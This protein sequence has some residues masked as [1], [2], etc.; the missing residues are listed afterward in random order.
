M[1]V[2]AQRTA[3]FLMLVLFL[4]ASTG[5]VLEGDT[6]WHIKTGEWIW[7]NH[8][9]PEVDVF[10]YTAQTK[11]PVRPHSVRHD[12]IMKG[13]WL[14]QPLLYL[15]H[16]TFGV[17]GLVMMRALMVALV[18]LVLHLWMQRL[19]VRFSIIIVSLIL[20]G[21]FIRNM[22][23]RP[24][25]FS[26]L[27]FPLAAQLLE[28]LR[29]SSEN[30]ARRRAILLLCSLML[31]WANMHGGYVMGV[32]LILIYLGPALWRSVQGRSSLSLVASY[33]AAVLITLI[34]PNTYKVFQGLY[35]EVTGGVQFKYVAEMMPAWQTAQLSGAYN[36][37]FWLALVLALITVMLRLRSMAIERVLA[38]LFFGVF[39]V[40]VQRIIFFFLL[41]IPFTAAEL[42]DL[43]GIRFRKAVRAAAALSIAVVLFTVGQNRQFLFNYSLDDMF[44]QESAQFLNTTKPRGN[45]FNFSDWGGYLMVHAPEYKV[46]H[47]GRRL[48]DDIETVH[49]YILLGSENLFQGV[50]LWKA[51]LDA[52]TIEI[53]LV[54]SVTPHMRDYCG[55][56][57]RLYRDDQWS[58]VFRDKVSLVYLKKGGQNDDL[59]RAHSLPKEIA[60]IDAI[61]RLHTYAT[62]AEQKRNA[63]IIADLYR[64]LNR[65]DEAKQYYNLS[66]SL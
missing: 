38:L 54:P 28:Y 17:P 3:I 12:L 49:A 65:P 5:P 50:P 26:F 24:H 52:F 9:I 55:I 18:L 42:S 37:T 30:R 8:A 41:L 1:N 13:Y 35:H 66:E 47:D 63:R 33:G 45:L 44:P 16:D 36:P 62:A 61:G 51:Y 64:L 59:I 48:M 60:L 6:F 20:V 56:V 7:R 53:I 2:I 21:F 32:I 22:G 25:Y 4:A 46:F 15:V 23:D 19:R 43:L 34:N 31:L 10:S 58:L 14:S 27:F 40:M 11:D 57:Q 39:A 29:T